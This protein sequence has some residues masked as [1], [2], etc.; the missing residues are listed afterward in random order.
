MGVSQT[1]KCFVLRVLEDQ[2]FPDHAR[3]N[4]GEGEDQNSSAWN[5][6]HALPKTHPQSR[7]GELDLSPP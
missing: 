2:G 7:L 3:L 6:G 1:S 4:R 5:V